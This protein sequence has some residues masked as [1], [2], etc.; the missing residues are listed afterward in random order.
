MSLTPEQ[1]AQAQLD[2]YNNKDLD[3]FIACYVPDIESRAHPGGEVLCQGHE[4]FRERYGPYFE[5]NP[6]MHC[7]L[8]HR[9]VMGKFV[10]DHEHITGLADGTEKYAIAVYAC[11]EE[12]IEGVWFLR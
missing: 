1:Q 6:E 5:A 7:E 8:L 4:G 9:M 12:Q 3:A 10:V 2:A 11:G